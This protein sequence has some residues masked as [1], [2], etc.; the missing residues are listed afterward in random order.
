[1]FMKIKLRDLKKWKKDDDGISNIFCF[2][3]SRLRVC[4]GTPGEQM[5]WT[6]TWQDQNR[7]DFSE[8][9]VR[10]YSNRKTFLI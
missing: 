3:R 8:K 6:A 1:M 5:C 7:L 4:G 10:L 9:R 2:F